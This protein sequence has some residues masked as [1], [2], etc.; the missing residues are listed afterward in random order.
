M[1]PKELKGERNQGIATKDK[2]LSAFSM[3]LPFFLLLAVYTFGSA[4]PTREEK[5]PLR[6]S[7]ELAEG[8]KNALLMVL[9]AMFDW[10]SQ[11]DDVTNENHAEPEL[12]N[13]EQ[14][15]LFNQP[16]AREKAACKNFFW[17]TFSTC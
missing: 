11:G 16:A 1:E 3:Q 2:Y 14:R 9:S 4:A 12:P 17:K 10:S 6:D 7:K 13:R 5:L 8:K 15:S